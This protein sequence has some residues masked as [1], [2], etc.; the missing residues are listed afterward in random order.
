MRRYFGVFFKLLFVRMYI[1]ISQS[2][3]ASERGHS[4]RQ[5]VFHA[6]YSRFPCNLDKFFN[7][8]PDQLWLLHGCKVAA[9][10]VAIVVHQ[11]TCRLDPTHWNWDKLFWEPAVSHRF[12]ILGHVG[13]RRGRGMLV[14]A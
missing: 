6:I 10:I 13:Q 9:L 1:Y 14:W 2:R 3:D 4:A 5:I 11:I 7:V 8:G 12:L